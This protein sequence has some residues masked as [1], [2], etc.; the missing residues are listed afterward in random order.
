MDSDNYKI[1][2]SISHSRI[3][4]EYFL[5]G[6]DNRILPING[7]LKVPLAFYCSS[8]GI[9]IGEGAKCAAQSGTAN[10]FDNYFDHLPN[11]EYYELNGSRYHVKNLLIDAS[12]SVFR[13]FYRNILLHAKGDLSANKSEMPLVIACEN[14]I[15]PHERNYIKEIFRTSGYVRTQVVEYDD[16]ID[17]YIKST[18]ANEYSCE[19]VLV[20]WTEGVDLTLKLFDLHKTSSSPQVILPKLGIDPRLDYVVKLIWEDIINQN[21]YLDFDENKTI[22]QNAASDFLGN[23]SPIVQE[24]LLIDGDSY[25]YSLNRHYI[26]QW[27]SN[28]SNEIK[29]GVDNLLKSNGITNKSK[30][31]LILRGIA[32]ENSYFKE[33][34]SNGFM[35]TICVNKTMRDDVMRLILDVN[36]PQIEVAQR[37]KSST[38]CRREI[39]DEANEKI[40]IEKNKDV[41]EKTTDVNLDARA[42]DM[43]NS[44][45]APIPSS[46]K[47]RWREVKAEVSAKIRG[48]KNQEAVDLL[49]SFKKECKKVNAVDLVAEVEAVRKDIKVEK[50]TTKS[51]KTTKSKGLEVPPPLPLPAPQTIKEFEG[52]WREIRAV[53]NAKVREGKNQEAIANLTS[54]LEECKKKEINA[55][56]PKIEAALED[57]PKNSPKT[58]STPKA[59]VSAPK[60]QKAT[61]VKS[62]EDG[63]SLLEAKKFKEARDWY[64]QNGDSAK[65]K[66]IVTLMRTQPEIAVR[67]KELQKHQTSKNKEQIKRIIVDLERYMSICKEVGYSDADTKK[68]I[69]DYKKIK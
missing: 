14:D 46:L 15:A 58:S 9:I 40:S 54:F 32:A 10:A 4:Y 25:D 2:I 12:E 37:P 59:K 29:L 41:L 68:L 47:R 24:S 7:L 11:S 44:V 66:L 8:T 1:I 5:E 63:I 30:V 35:K 45:P 6:G 21:P 23:S 43:N 61:K 39:K 22:L 48:G 13:D 16:F 26:G 67:K 56:I 62:Q 55:L 36:I 38:D 34:L 64:T 42:D 49:N 50:K 3:S 17:R 53:S 19:K 20:A 18:I 33:I 28:E 69:S 60:S 31:L 51:T 57:A 65:A 27:S 52:R